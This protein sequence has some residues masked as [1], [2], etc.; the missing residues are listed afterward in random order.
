M[1]EAQ[2]LTKRY[3]GRG[4]G[5]TA[6]ENVSFTCAPGTVTG[7]LGRKGGRG[8]GDGAGKSTTLKMLCGLAAPT[9]GRHA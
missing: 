5:R 7:Y 6:V 2:S 1:I 3:G 4:G 9:S 8:G